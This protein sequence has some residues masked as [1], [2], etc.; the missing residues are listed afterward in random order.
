[1]IKFEVRG[2]RKS[3]KIYFSTCTEAFLGAADLNFKQCENRKHDEQKKTLR[4][5]I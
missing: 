4:D 2:D 1:M 3:P 5:G